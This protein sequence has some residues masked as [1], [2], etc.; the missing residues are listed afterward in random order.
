MVGELGPYQIL[1]P[2]YNNR[3]LYFIKVVLN[4][5]YY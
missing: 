5:Y 4:D 3:K 2:L 1:I